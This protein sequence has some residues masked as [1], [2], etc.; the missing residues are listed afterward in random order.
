MELN[1]LPVDVANC[2]VKVLSPCHGIVSFAMHVVA[3]PHLT[4]LQPLTFV[5]AQCLIQDLECAVSVSP[6]T[7]F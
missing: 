3:A 4:I 7:H 5:C 2:C 1:F 6:K